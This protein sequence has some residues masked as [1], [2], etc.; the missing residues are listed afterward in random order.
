MSGSLILRIVFKNSIKEKYQILN[1]EL[2]IQKVDQIFEIFSRHETAPVLIKGLAAAQNY[3]Q[4][5]QRAFS[6]IDIAVDPRFYK[7]AQEIIAE[8]HFNIDLHRGLRHLDILE[9]DD[10]FKNSKFIKIGNSNVRVLSS[11]DHLRVLCV[12][13]LNDG[14]A[15]RTR[16]WDI[17]FALQNK[18]ATFDWERFYGNVGEKRKKWLMTVI[19]LTKDY[20]DLQIKDLPIDFTNYE[21]PVWVKKEIETEWGS[22]FRLTPL[23]QVLNDRKQLF[24][25][26]LKR[27][28]PNAL[29]A[30]VENDAELTDE[31]STSILLMNVLKRIKPSIKRIFKLDTEK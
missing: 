26:V 27:L 31:K 9:W 20:L 21:I 19:L 14:G 11:E 13:W 24:R 6:D 29:Q 12:H 25:Q 4:P 10:L 8:N 15:D 28:P 16:I 3:P 23:Q 30:V 5:H 18:P 17:Y 1:Y 2:N 7:T 22:D